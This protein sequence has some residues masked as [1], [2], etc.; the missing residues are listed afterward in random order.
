M[1]EYS[2]VSV[3]WDDH[4]GFHKT[5]LLRNPER[6]MRPTLTIGFIYRQTKK[7]MTIVSDLERYEEGDEATY[8]VIFKSTIRAMTEYGKIKLANVGA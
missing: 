3:L 8:V 6:T 5:K 4:T 1:K 7:T 2:V